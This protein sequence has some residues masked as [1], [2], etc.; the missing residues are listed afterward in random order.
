MEGSAV[1]VTC[2]GGG[3]DDSGA[4]APVQKLVRAYYAA[5][6]R[7][8]PLE[9]FYATDAEAGDLGPAVK[10]GSGEGEVFAGYD[11]IAAEVRRVTSTFAENRL[12]SRGLEVRRRGDVAWFAD[13]VWW[14]GVADGTP[15]ASL[16]RWSGVCL[17]CADAWKFVQV[18]VSEAA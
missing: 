12:D 7:G 18:H 16:T 3:H 15:F 6:E 14:S 13:Q 2:G 5:L 1:P 9:G 10:I 17:R 8:A 11:A 4:L